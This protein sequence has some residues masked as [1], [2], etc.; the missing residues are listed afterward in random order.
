MKRYH[1]IVLSA[2]L[3]A[4]CSQTPVLK[5]PE[6]ALPIDRLRAELAEKFDDP[7]FMNAHWG[8]VIRSLKTGEIVYQRNENKSFMPAS[9]MKLFT[10]STALT[11]LT[12]DFR[13]RTELDA[14]GTVAD[15]VLTG[16]LLVKGSGDP[17]ISGRY[18]N[19]HST[20]TFEWWAD[21]LKAKGITAIRGN[22]VG[23]DRCFDDSYYGDGWDALYET[24]WYAA[25]FSGI[26]Y[27]DDCVD[28][29]V[30][31]ADSIGKPASVDWS[32]KTGYITVIN[33]TVT[34][35]ADS[36][37][38]IT[39]T[40]RRGT[41][42]VTVTGAFPINKPAW[43]ESIAIDNPTLYAMTVLKET[44]EKKGITVTGAPVDIGDTDL[45]PDYAAAAHIA[46]FTSIP[47]SQIVRTINKPSQNFYAEQLFR[48]MG[49]TFY[50]T[51]SERNSRRV[52]R[53]IFASWGIDTL[54]LQ[55]VDGSGLSRLNLVSPTDVVSLLTGMYQGKYFEPFYQSL[56]IAGV[57]GS[58]KSRMKGT[59]AENNVHAKTGFVG[60]V[61]ALS[62]YVTSAD[63]EMFAFSMIC[64]HYTVPTRM[65]E[66][67]Q[68]DVCVRLAEFSRNKQ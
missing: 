6:P 59:K 65:A 64:N 46:S 3:F 10:T 23:D 22:I 13:Y 5:S 47:L 19:G 53:P 14:E 27:N 26:A 20:E 43:K 51:G 54:R 45:K 33:K 25:Q 68:N 36:E 1:W 58:I 38:Y 42:I 35:A 67:I 30:T 18:N 11:S 12:P 40:R 28:M 49:M 17:T 50:G 62:G 16:N 61:R 41:N 57:D 48:T 52:T 39:F 9:N 7:N 44:L 8:V 34:T 4:S 32:P 60:Y 2:A 31:A 63:G 24:D 55:E 29:T 37:Y 21:S 15:G 56:P 66:K